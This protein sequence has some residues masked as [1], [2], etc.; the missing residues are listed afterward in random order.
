M[1]N[2]KQLKSIDNL[3]EIVEKFIVGDF[4]QRE[5]VDKIDEADKPSKTFKKMADTLVMLINSFEK[6][7]KERTIKLEEKNKELRENKDQLQLILDSTVEAIYGMDIEGKCTFCNASGLKMLGYLSQEELLGKDIHLQIHHTF[8][9]GRDMPLE[10]CKIYKALLD[11]KGTH[12]NDEV[13][14]RKDGTS[15]DVEYHSY[16]QFKDGEIIGAVVTFMDNTD[17]KKSEE[18][19]RYLSYHDSLTGI[20]NRMFFEEQLKRLDTKKNLPLSIIFGD[21]NGLKLTNDIFGHAAGDELLKKSAEIFKRVCRE[22]DIVARVG[23]DEFA[24]LLPNTEA[25]D[26]D[27]IMNRIRD[28]FSKEKIIAIKGSISLGYETKISSDEHIERT[29]EKA[30]QWMYKE[31]MLNR[32]DIDSEMIKTII[33]TLHNRSPEEMEHSRSVSDLCEKIGQEMKMSETEV[34]KLKDAGFLHDIGKIVLEEDMLNRKDIT[35]EESKKLEQHS[36]IGYRILNLFDDTLDLAEG[37]LGHHENWDGSGYPKGLMGE[38]IPKIARIIRIVEC[39]HAMTDGTKGDV[40]SKEE[41]LE[42][43]KNQSEVIFDPEIVDVF[44]KMMS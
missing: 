1:K 30:E 8:K 17:R 31:K 27:K 42:E 6:K 29:M 32:K 22:E 2:N 14:W 26:A 33:E 39:Y 44:V 24:V 16:P 40:M 18:R 35:D 21:V 34:R 37:V 13:F 15:F 23:G 20:F 25:R 38:E 28:E 12:A 10:E 19:I 9:D 11:K 5:F 7:V 41:A 43:I 36:V 3:I 4:S